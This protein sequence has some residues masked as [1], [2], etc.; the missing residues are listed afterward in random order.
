MRKIIQLSMVTVI[1]ASMLFA[2]ADKMKRYEIKSGKI[3]YDIST[4]GNVMGM[5]KIESKGTKKSLLMITG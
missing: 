1:G 4:S 2:S 5:V 3:E